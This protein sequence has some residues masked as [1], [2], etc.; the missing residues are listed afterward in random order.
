[1]HTGNVRSP[2]PDDTVVHRISI[3]S[4][5]HTVTDIVRFSVP[6][7]RTRYTSPRPSLH[8]DFFPTTIA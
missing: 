4:T 8:C 7:V 2:P 1:M 6:I 3:A 5:M